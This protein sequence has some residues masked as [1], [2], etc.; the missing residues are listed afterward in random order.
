[1]IEQFLVNKFFV[2]SWIFIC[3]LSVNVLLS[4]SPISRYFWSLDHP[5]YGATVYLQNDR[6]TMINSAIMRHI[7]EDIDVV[8]SSQNNL[9][10]HRISTRKVVGSFPNGVNR[11]F[12]RLSYEEISFHSFF[13]F[14]YSNDHHVK[15]FDE[16]YAD[17]IIV[18]RK[19]PLFLV[20]QGCE[21]INGVCSN[22]EIVKQFNAEL[23]LAR[24]NYATVYIND[25]FE[26]LKKSSHQTVGK[27]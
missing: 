23:E 21:W 10:N 16:Y 19:R 24:K 18:D 6:E 7:P 14:I 13:G 11:P 8:V 25:G 17:Y 4:P 15:T 5:R 2:S 22:D 20:D 1:M 9:N 3:A 27:L 26:I 12:R